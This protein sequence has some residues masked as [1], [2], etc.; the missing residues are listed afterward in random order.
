VTEAVQHHVIISGTGRAGTSFLMQLLT[1]LGLPTGF[2]DDDTLPHLEARAG[3]EFDIRNPGAPYIAKS[4][5]FCDFAP[6]V[7]NR[8]DIVIDHVFIPMRN[9]EAAAESRRYV[10]ETSA[11]DPADARK[12]SE[13][14]GGLWHT[15]TMDD[16]E[17]VLL[18][19]I[20]KL[21]LAL[22]DSEIPV[23]LMRYPRITR[24]SHYLY[25]KL[26]PILSGIGFELFQEV[27][28]RTARPELVHK[29]NPD[30]D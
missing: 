4:P 8:D 15:D 6:E 12:P 11:T 19:Q 9:L 26:R 29:F 25:N 21:T 23:T 5:F 14:P 30:D 1:R 7:I 2:S 24:D 10:V 20:Y 27:F 17:Q 13:I 22:S 3:L 18:G 28:D 16:Q